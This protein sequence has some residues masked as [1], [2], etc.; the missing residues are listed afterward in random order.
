MGREIRKVPA[1]WQ[2]PV[3]EDHYG[4]MRKQPMYDR[5]FEDAFS[6]W[7]AEFGRF[8]AG[9]LTD[10]ERTWYP[11]GLASWLA[12]D[13]RP[14]EPAY[15]RPWKREDAT[16]FQVWENVS[17]GTPVT[18]PFATKAELVDYLVKN[19]D[20]WDQNRGQGG[21][22]RKAAEQFVKDEYAPSLIVMQDA[23]GVKIHEPRDGAI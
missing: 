6:E 15:Y 9:K 22:S 7:L 1:N 13:G 5:A 14:P 12:E 18:P 3:T 19:G 21:W 4:R 8:R 11:L 23:S 17:E 2:H 16:W 20:E 10:D